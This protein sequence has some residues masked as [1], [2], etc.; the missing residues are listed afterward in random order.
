MED[1]YD[2]RFFRINKRLDALESLVHYS[3]GPCSICNGSGMVY[4][5]DE[6]LGRDITRPCEDCRGSGKMPLDFVR[7]ME[8]FK[9]QARKEIQTSNEIP[10]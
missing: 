2:D 3:I 8:H 10:F 6:D 9:I 1:T 7:M 4:D 5:Q